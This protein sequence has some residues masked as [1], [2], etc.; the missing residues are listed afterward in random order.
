MQEKKLIWID[1]ETLGLN[2][3]KSPLI[4]VGVVI[5]D[6]QLNVEEKACFSI[7]L[8]RNV[9]LDHSPEMGID[10]VAIEMHKIN[11]LLEK[12]LNSDNSVEYVESE[13]INMLNKYQKQSLILTNLSVFFDRDILRFRMPNLF[14]HQAFHWRCR[15]ISSIREMLSDY[16]VVP[17]LKTSKVQVSHTPIEDIL[18]AISQYKH[19]IDTLKDN[20][21]I[22]NSTRL[23]LAEWVLDPPCKWTT[24]P[25]SSN[26]LF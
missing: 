9:V 8:D 13:L 24:P 12:S 7:K 2:V 3:V 25:V 15:D 6:M 4:A 20:A 5:T 23:N 16:D 26:N 14:T 18:F 21:H 19:I 11:G 1:F 22:T 17:D 10:N